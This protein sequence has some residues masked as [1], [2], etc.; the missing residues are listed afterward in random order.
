MTLPGRRWVV[1]ALLATPCGAGAQDP[2]HVLDSIYDAVDAGAAKPAVAVAIL[3]R[4][5]V[6]Y[7]RAAGFADLERHV[8]AVTGTRFDWASV[9][10]QFTGF[11][12]AQ[13]AEAGALSPDDPARKLLPELDLS[14]ATVTVDQLL[15]HTSG[16]EDSDGLLALAGWRPGDVV[17][18]SDVLRILLGQKHVR[19]LPGE[20]EG[21]GNG[22]Y[23]LLAEIVARASG[24]SFA[25]YT[26]SAIFRA[27]GMSASGFPGSPTALVPDRALPYVRGDDGAFVGSRVD[28]YVGAGGLYATVD[29]MMI[30]AAELLH[31]ARDAAAVA[32]IESPGHLASGEPLSY[33]WGIVVGSY[34]GRAT[35][36]H[37][38]SGVATET[39]FEVF[40]E[41]DFAVAAASAAPGIVDPARVARLA[42]DL[43]VGAELDPV[44]PPPPGPR[45]ML[46]TDS[47]ISTPPPE[48]RDV[49]VPR[50]RLSSLAGAYRFADGSVLVVRRS[51]ERLEYAQNGEAPFIPLF[52]VPGDRFV[53]MPL[54]IPYTFETTPDGSAARLIV[55]HPRADG[56]T[57]REVG[58][59]VEVPRFDATSAAPYVGWYYSDELGA[60]YQV[61]LG[62]AGLELS[63]PRLGALPLLPLGMGDDFGVD[64]RTIVGVAFSRGPDG[65]ASGM[66][67]R[68]RSWDARS[69]FRRVAG[70][71]ER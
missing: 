71:G 44:G 49:H 45:M 36:S 7:H 5:Q 12:V 20:Q 23:A 26:D 69:F 35:L 52:P 64:A 29:D 38:G 14:G 37:G 10:K 63:H 50:E 40:P 48:S 57:Q 43:Y 22:G 21:Y 46:L 66:E 58:E 70:P 24:M 17:D 67:L 68:A 2:A 11:A 27:L 53:M 60:V 3:H 62:S 15:H 47:M 59:R 56:G 1:A 41:L 61:S 33:G 16:L 28:G 39:Y 32:R 8:R 42:A 31:P 54:R 13:L 18:D 19:W 9:A 51:G 55:D 6:V 25:A 30:W 65:R 34:R 4:G